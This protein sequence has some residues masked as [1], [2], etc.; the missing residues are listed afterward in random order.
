M[1][2][3]THND[4]N[5]INV[6]MHFNNKRGPVLAGLSD[7]DSIREGVVRLP[8]GSLWSA[9]ELLLQVREVVPRPLA[10]VWAAVWIPWSTTTARRSARDT[11]PACSVVGLVRRVA[12]VCTLVRAGPALE[13]AP[14]PLL[15][16]PRWTHSKRVTAA[17]ARS[18]WSERETR[19]CSDWLTDCLAHT[20]NSQ[21]EEENCELPLSTRSRKPKFKLSL[22]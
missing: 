1:T 12:R 3:D 15:G 13:P 6:Y 22:G 5:K 10:P 2:L 19:L 4:N 17:S 20:P 18:Y 8:P 11:W 14:E 16:S 7:L 9:P 21:N